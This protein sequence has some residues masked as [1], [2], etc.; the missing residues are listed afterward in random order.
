MNFITIF[1]SAVI[2]VS[3]AFAGLAITIFLKKGGRFPNTHIHGNKYLNE[4]GI[5]CVQT[6]D[7]REQK[8][9][10]AKIDYRNLTPDKK[11][12][13]EGIFKTPKE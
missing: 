2:I 6:Y 12:M 10:K 8:K 7:A 9:V 1:L 13:E 5:S 11:N 3:I 4:Q